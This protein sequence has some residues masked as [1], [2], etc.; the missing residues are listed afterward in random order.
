MAPENRRHHVHPIPAK[1]QFEIRFPRVEGYTQAIPFFEIPSL[2]RKLTLMGPGEA[3]VDTNLT[4]LG[5]EI[6]AVTRER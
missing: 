3:F 4:E 2:A 5:D 1:A 6:K